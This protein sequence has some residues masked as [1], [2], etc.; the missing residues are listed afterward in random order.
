[1]FRNIEELAAKAERRRVAQR[2]ARKGN[3]DKARDAADRIQEEIELARMSER[4]SLS[5]KARYVQVSLQKDARPD[6][7]VPKVRTIREHLAAHRDEIGD[8]R[9]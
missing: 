4:T 2:A 3:E 7:W 1:M 9:K 8:T 5:A 6:D